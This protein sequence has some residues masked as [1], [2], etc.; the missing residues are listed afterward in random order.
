M[1]QLKRLERF[2]AGRRGV[3]ERLFSARAL[4]I[5]GFLVMPAL[6]FNPNT[7]FRILQFLFFWFLAWLSGKKNNPLVT[8]TII[9]GIVFFNLLVP[10]GQVLFSLGV[11]RVTIG[12]LTAGIHRAVTLEGLIMLSRVSIRRDLRIPG[13]FGELI[14]ESFRLFAVIMDSR[15]RITRKNLTGD[16]DALMLELGEDPSPGSGTPPAAQGTSPEGMAAEA[17]APQQRT[18]L[19][20]FIILALMVILSW[21]PLIFIFA[22]AAKYNS[23]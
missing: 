23:L 11:F 18:T 15:Q 7:F 16:I 3:Y 2:R 1:K 9:A 12:A 5:A 21:L 19:A 20:G 6:L 8:I 17:P 10:Y 22:L 14:G 4:C 13:G